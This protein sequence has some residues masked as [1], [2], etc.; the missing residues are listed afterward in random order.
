MCGDSSRG[1]QHGQ[2]LSQPNEVFVFQLLLRHVASE[3]I[4][5]E[6]SSATGTI[7]AGC[8]LKMEHLKRISFGQSSRA[9]INAIPMR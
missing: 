8:P 1:L 7:I 5:S 6:T 9:N 3:F 2:T 4:C